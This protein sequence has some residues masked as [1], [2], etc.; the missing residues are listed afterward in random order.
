MTMNEADD[1]EA[2]RRGIDALRKENEE[3]LATLRQLIRETH[4][5]TV[6]EVDAMEQALRVLGRV[7][8][9]DTASAH[10]APR[11]H[12]LFRARGAD[13]QAVHGPLQRIVRRAPRSCGVRPML[14]PVEDR[15][16]SKCSQD[17]ANYGPRSRG[18]LNGCAVDETEDRPDM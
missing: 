13:I 12:N 10:Q 7:Q 8:R 16:E 4:P 15:E 9:N 2:L 3:L 1:L 11:A 5:R 17:E 6:A 18:A 14:E